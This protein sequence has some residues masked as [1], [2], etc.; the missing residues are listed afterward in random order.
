MKKLIFILL[1]ISMGCTK[2]A[3]LEPPCADFLINQIQGT[4]ETIFILNASESTGEQLQYKVNWGFG[5]SDYTTN[6]IFKY[7]YDTI[8][9]FVINLWVKDFR[10][11]TDKKE[12]KI[13]IEK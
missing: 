2:Q 7:K 6:P 11:W 4:I 9:E 3:I 10:G 1:I 8:G 5:F 13:L 12:I